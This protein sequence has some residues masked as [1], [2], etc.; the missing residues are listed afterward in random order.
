MV[1]RA[2]TP[3]LPSCR[4]PPSPNNQLWTT[5]LLTVF[6]GALQIAIGVWASTFN[7]SVIDNALTIAGFSSGILLGL[8]ALGVFTKRTNQ[9]A[10]LA[11]GFIGL[12][13]MLFIQFVLPT[14][15]FKLAF[16][17]LAVFGSVITYLSGL[18]LSAFLAPS[19]E[20][21]PK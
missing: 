6:F 3:W 19:L 11:G 4:V 12:L 7:K 2:T 15:G 16:P 9:S 21:T 17:W 5:R 18:I 1:R 20:A 13:A 8:F 14:W 10:A